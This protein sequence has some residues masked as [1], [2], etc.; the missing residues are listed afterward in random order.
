MKSETEIENEVIEINKQVQNLSNALPK[1]NLNQRLVALLWVLGA[2][3]PSKLTFS[4]EQIEFLGN[5]Y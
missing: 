1:R 3:K 5:F 4:D 2:D